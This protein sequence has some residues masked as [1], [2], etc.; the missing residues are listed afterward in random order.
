MDFRDGYR[1]EVNSVTKRTYMLKWKMVA[2]LD[3]PRAA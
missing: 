3:D 1:I 2:S